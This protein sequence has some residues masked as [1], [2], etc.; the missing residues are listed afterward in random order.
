MAQATIT[1][2][3]CG[4]RV[5][6][7][8]SRQS[9][10]DTKTANRLN[11]FTRIGSADRHHRSSRNKGTETNQVVPQVRDDVARCQTHRF[12]PRK[13]I[14]LHIEQFIVRQIDQQPGRDRRNKQAE[15]PARPTSW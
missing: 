1:N 10:Q 9:G 13:I 5:H 15:P 14:Q 12:Q 3:G 6:S 11:A 8:S 4:N 2:Q 7:K